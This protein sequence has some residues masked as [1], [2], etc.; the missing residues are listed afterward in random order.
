MN[1]TPT[2]ADETSDLE[3]LHDRL[4]RAAAERDVLDVA[5]RRLDSPIGTL[6]VA[7]TPRGVVRLAFENEIVDEVLDELVTKVSPRVLETPR[8]LD[9]V[10]RE[11]EE[12]FAG[13]RTRFDVSID[14]TLSSGF[15]RRVLGHL[16]Q[17]PYG[18]TESYT[19]VAVATDNPKAVRAVGSACATNPVPLIVPCHR[20]L[21]SDGSL[22]GYRGGLAAKRVLLDL[23]AAA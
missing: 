18:V 14:F 15:R 11:L 1:T 7:A 19:E 6:V 4:A 21:R 17:I 10:A 23:E 16:T 20:V 8:G 3:R 13:T 5:F 12:Y 2:L 22:G 9:E